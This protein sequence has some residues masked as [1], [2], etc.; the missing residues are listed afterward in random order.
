MSARIQTVLNNEHSEM[1]NLRPIG[2]N[3]LV[4]WENG[5]R[6]F[7]TLEIP[8]GFERGWDIQFGKVLAVGTKAKANTRNGPVKYGDRVIYVRSVNKKVD[9]VDIRSERGG[10]VAFLKD[11]HALALVTDEEIVPINNVCL[12][13]MPEAVERKS[14]IF[15]TKSDSLDILPCKILATGPDVNQLEVGEWA[16]APKVNGV[17]IDSFELRKRFG[18]SLKLIKQESIEGAASTNEVE[19][20]SHGA[21][22]AEPVAKRL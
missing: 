13:R 10:K 21:S 17:E 7:G 6:M 14:L 2:D 11:I 5:S 16:I 3:L 4:E 1:R 8:G 9:S 15:L 12:V 22:F 18:L 19:G 20:F